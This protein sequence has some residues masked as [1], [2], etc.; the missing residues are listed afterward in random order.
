MNN[1]LYPKFVQINNHQ[2]AVDIFNAVSL[3]AKNNFCG[4]LVAETPAQDE[5]PFP[6]ATWEERHK[7]RSIIKFNFDETELKTGAKLSRAPTPYPKELR[8]LAK[9]ARNLSNLKGESEGKQVVGRRS[10]REESGKTKDDGKVTGEYQAAAALP[11]QVSGFG[12]QIYFTTLVHAKRKNE[13]QSGKTN[14]K[15]E[16]RI[17]KRNDELQS[18]TTNYKA[19]R[20]ITKRNDKLQSG[21]TNYKAERQITKR[22][23]KLQSGKANYKAE[24]QITK[25][26]DEGRGESYV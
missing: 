7:A 4:W 5:E 8:A 18:G 1:G 22:N 16:R 17:T 23:D 19:E 10:S 13:L 14:Y 25:R 2:F 20:R 12:V 3:F 6:M 26:K 11:A 9:H 15:A 21:T 24:R